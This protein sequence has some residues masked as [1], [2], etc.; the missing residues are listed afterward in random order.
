MAS[1]C[2]P[3]SPA[4]CETCWRRNCFALPFVRDAV[5]GRFAGTTLR[6][7]RQRGQN[8]L[9]GTRATEIPLRQGTLTHV[10]RT[11]GFVLIREEGAAPVGVPRLVEA[12]RPDAGPPVLV[13]PDGYI[14]W[15]GASS[16]REGLTKALGRW[17]GSQ[18]SG[19]SNAAA[20]AEMPA[21]TRSSRRRRSTAPVV[22]HAT[23][24]PMTLEPP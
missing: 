23:Q 19:R 4:A 6:Y 9:V 13:R 12:E 14:A 11:A 8:R 7:P 18:L 24:P 17:T 1:P 20:A 3:E 2:L 15:V 21:S 22:G 16:D 5:A 10:Q